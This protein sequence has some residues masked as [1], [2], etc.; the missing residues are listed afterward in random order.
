ERG[1]RGRASHA[2]A[3]TGAGPGRRLRARR[4]AGGRGVDRRDRR[5]PLRR[6][7]GARGPAAQLVAH[8]VALH[9]RRPAHADGPAAGAGGG[10]DARAGGQRLHRAL[11]A[12]ARADRVPGARARAPHRAVR[13]HRA[14]VQHLRGAQPDRHHGPPGDQQHPADERRG[15]L[16]GGVGVLGGGAARQPTAREV[17]AD[18]AL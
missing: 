11:R 5:R 16:V 17:P 13:P 4:R 6:H 9:P 15:P 12:A 18:R 8:A 3:R 1:A 14:R 7:L 10:G 2:R